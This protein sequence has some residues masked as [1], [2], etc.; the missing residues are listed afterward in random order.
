MFDTRALLILIP[1]LPLVA[2]IVTAVLGP[3]VLRQNSHWPAVVGIIGSFLCSV[4]IAWQAQ[5]SPSEHLELVPLWTWANVTDAYDPPHRIADPSEMPLTAGG[6]HSLD[7][8]VVQR[9]LA[10][11]P[12][13]DFPI[14]SVSMARVSQIRPCLETSHS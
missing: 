2:A 13:V 3:R 1:A 4:A 7:I 8:E 5:D 12:N 14:P 6:L 11:Y 9:P 10:K